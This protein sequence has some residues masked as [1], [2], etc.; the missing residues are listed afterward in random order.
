MKTDLIEIFQ[1]IRA[2]MQPYAAKGF[3]VKTNTEN[4]YDLWSEKN[5]VFAGKKRNE[6]HFATVKINKNYVALHFMPVYVETDIK[7]LFHENL[8]KLLKGKACFHIKKLDDELLGHIVVALKA[9]DTLYK[10]KQWV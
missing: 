9:G 4:E 3:S 2:S 6:V 10:Q 1:S 5:V 8:L 7:A